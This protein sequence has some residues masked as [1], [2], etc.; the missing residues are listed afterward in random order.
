MSRLNGSFLVSRNIKHV[1][2]L[3]RFF[4]G[5]VLSLMSIDVTLQIGILGSWLLL[6][7][8]ILSFRLK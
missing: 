6:F 1:M 5:Y 7:T 2:R 3:V 8:V 4:N